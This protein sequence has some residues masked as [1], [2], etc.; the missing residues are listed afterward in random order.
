MFVFNK[1]CIPAGCEPGV[2]RKILC[3]S[4]ELM[5]CE[6]TFE[7]GAQGYFHSHEHLQITYIAEGV[8][9]FTIGDEKKTVRKGDGVYMPSGVRHGVTC[10][11]AG[12]LVDVFNPM[13][14]DFL[15]GKEKQKD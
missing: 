2:T 1:D 6:I 7:E 5:M 4:D 3:Y 13:R 9:E 14:R 12:K 8:F 15:A 11:E 10:L